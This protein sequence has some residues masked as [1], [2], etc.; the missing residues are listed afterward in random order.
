MEKEIHRNMTFKDGS[1][2]SDSTWYFVDDED[3]LVSAINDMRTGAD[4]TD[5]SDVDYITFWDNDGNEY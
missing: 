2:Y 4:G 5:V 3:E 1:T